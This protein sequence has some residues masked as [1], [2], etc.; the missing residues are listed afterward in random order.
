MTEA[1]TEVVVRRA[2]E[3][4]LEAAIALAATALG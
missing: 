3:D 4:D 1:K 2:T